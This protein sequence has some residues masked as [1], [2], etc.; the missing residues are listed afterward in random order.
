[1][2][3]E[4]YNRKFGKE[5]RST[6][7]AHR[8]LRE[9]DN[10]ERIFAR[11]SIRKVSKDL[12]FQYNGTFYQIQTNLPNQFRSAYVNILERSGKPILIEAGGILAN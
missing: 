2:F 6:E 7:D 5:A 10:L 12:S 1:M 8:E 3:I 9:T 4:E 11:R